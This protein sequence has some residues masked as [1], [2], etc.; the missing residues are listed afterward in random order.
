MYGICN[1]SR[2]N[3]IDIFKW[4]IYNKVLQKCMKIPAGGFIL[5]FI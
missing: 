3:I 5:K 1:E 2:N 4:K